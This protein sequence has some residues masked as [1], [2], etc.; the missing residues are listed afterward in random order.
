MFAQAA[1]EQLP[2]TSR[3]GALPAA[4]AL[5]GGAGARFPRA[6]HRQRLLRAR[7]GQQRRHAC[8]VGSGQPRTSAPAEP[9]VDPA[10]HR[11]RGH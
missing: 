11:P 9:A 2:T 3:A 1:P 4:A 10:I 6:P 5:V 8:P 7:G